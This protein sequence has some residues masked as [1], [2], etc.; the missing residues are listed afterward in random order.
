MSNFYAK[1]VKKRREML[2][3]LSFVGLIGLVEVE[4]NHIGNILAKPR[5]KLSGNN[6]SVLAAQGMYLIAFMLRG[7]HS[8]CD[9]LQSSQP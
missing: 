7:D 9:H 4:T 6:T 3:T 1:K 5:K 2:L 8:H